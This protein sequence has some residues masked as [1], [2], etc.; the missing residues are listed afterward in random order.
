MERM[1]PNKGEKTTDRW[2]SLA[3]RLNPARASFDP[4]FKAAWKRL[5]K[6][7]RSRIV[8]EDK[9]KIRELQ[10]RAQP[11][12]FPTDSDDHCETSKTAYAHILPFLQ[13]LAKKLAKSPHELRIYDPYYCA[14]ATV[15][16]LGEL[17]FPH[18]HNQPDDF[19]RIIATK[20]VPYHDIL[21]TNPPYSGDHF[22][23][24]KSFLSTNKKPHLLLVP[25]HFQVDHE[26][27]TFLKPTE[28]YHYWT[29]RGMRPSE[30]SKKRKHRNLMLGS[31]NSPFPSKW[32]VSLE[33]VVSKSDLLGV[34]LGNDCTIHEM[35]AMFVLE[36]AK[37]RPKDEQIIEDQTADTEKKK[38]R[39]KGK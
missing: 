27:Y 4:E 26:K 33:P 8:E 21:I 20:N 23:K 18:V 11:L 9:Q 17:G 25:N 14:G 13:L 34:K 24:L 39:K 1:P 19:Y 12:P 3:D 7:A 28:R 32:C 5:D 2:V 31:R 16:H 22:D 35:D 38:K 36:G 29:P 37:F 6:A 15:R 10:E 30:E